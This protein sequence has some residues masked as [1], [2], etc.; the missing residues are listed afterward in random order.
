MR[1]VT[2][3]LHG[4]P[5]DSFRRLLDS[6]GFSDTD[7]LIVLGDVIDRNGDGGVAALRWLMD[8]KNARFI[9]GNH[10][11]M[12]LDCRFLFDGSVT[13]ESFDFSGRDRLGPQEK[14]RLMLL[15]QWTRNGARPTMD[16]L[17]A[18]KREDPSAL[19]ALIGYLEAA[20]L[21]ETFTAGDRRYILTHSGLGNFDPDRALDSYTDNDLIWTRPQITD[22][23]YPDATVVFGHTPTWFYGEEYEGRMIR[24]DTW[25]DIDTGA[26]KPGGHPMLLR[27][28]DER[29]F[30]ADQD[31]KKGY[32]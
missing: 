4:Y 14:L 13:A 12:L 17:A 6:A 23:Y 15:R 8:M 9:L 1:Y 21:Y 28:E 5:L 29:P 3:D 16:S 32:I 26:A 27:L 30:Y 2:S 7:E 10:E 24:T 11:S 22:R 31:A 20:P 19:S 18:L 25:I